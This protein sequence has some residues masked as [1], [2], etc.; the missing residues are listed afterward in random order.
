MADFTTT[1]K[2]YLLSSENV[3]LVERCC[4]L[5]LGETWSSAFFG[6]DGLGWIIHILSSELWN[7]QLGVEIILEAKL[8]QMSK[9]KY[10]NMEREREEHSINK[11][12][13]KDGQTCR[14]RKTCLDEWI[15]KMWYIHTVECYSAIKRNETESFVVM[16]MNLKSVIWSEVS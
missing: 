15:N 14:D 2:I 11:R 10:G 4:W 16:W 9:L 1:R 8:Q 5:Y 7:G 3:F 13:K 6:S 12:R